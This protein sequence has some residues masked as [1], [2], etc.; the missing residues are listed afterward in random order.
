MRPEVNFVRHSAT[1][2]IDIK[3]TIGIGKK[4]NGPKILIN[5]FSFYL[6]EGFKSYKVQ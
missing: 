6:N 5:G 2:I 4:T 3:K 1:E